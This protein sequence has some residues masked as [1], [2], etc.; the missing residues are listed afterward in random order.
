MVEIPFIHVSE[1]QVPFFHAIKGGV[2]KLKEVKELEPALEKGMGVGF[3]A[4]QG[5][6]RV[7]WV[8]VGT[9][10]GGGGRAHLASHISPMGASKGYLVLVLLD[11]GSSGS[12]RA[13]HIVSSYTLSTVS[14]V[15]C[16][17]KTYLWIKLD[18]I[19]AKMHKYK[20]KDQAV[21]DVPIKRVNVWVLKREMLGY[22]G[23]ALV[24]DT[25]SLAYKFTSWA[26][27]P[28]WK[29]CTLNLVI[30]PSLVMFS[31]KM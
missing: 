11:E 1:W 30:Y 20:L 22:K 21:S 9:S 14:F 7:V 26:I 5:A 16:I 4:E 24:G 25:I 29:S 31:I 12:F 28:W 10:G 23:V 8:K 18:I 15:V 27:K 19:G 13:Q 17:E 6:I 2:K 3:E